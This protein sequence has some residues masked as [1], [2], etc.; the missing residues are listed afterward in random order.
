MSLLVILEYITEF[1]K[2]NDIINLKLTNKYI[3]INIKNIYVSVF[4]ETGTSIGNILNNRYFIEHINCNQIILYSSVNLTKFYNYRSLTLGN[5]KI[6]EFEKIK[7]DI[8]HLIIDYCDYENMDNIEI[9]KLYLLFLK[10]LKI[11]NLTIPLIFPLF[12]NLLPENLVILTLNNYDYDIFEDVLPKNLQILKFYNFNKIIKNNIL[13]KNLKQLIFGRNFN[14]IIE[15]EALPD[16]LEYINFNNSYTQNIYEIKLPSMLKILKFGSNY[17]I[18]IQDYIF[19][20]KLR[21]LYLPRHYKLLNIR[22]F[23]LQQEF[24]GPLSNKYMKIL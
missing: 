7:L 5:I 13:P 23:I 19:P 9:I 11:F 12:K 18:N 15:N 8:D 1:L 2:I 6:S 3:N 24:N 20:H 10:K 4:D 14:S 16:S 22:N 21:E 17:N